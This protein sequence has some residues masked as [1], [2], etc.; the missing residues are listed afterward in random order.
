MPPSI[1]TKFLSKTEEK[2]DYFFT[3]EICQDKI[4]TAA[5]ELKQ[6][7]VNILGVGAADGGGSWE[8]TTIAVDKAL[9]LVEEKFPPG[10]KVNKVVLGLPTEYTQDGKI[11]ENK[12]VSIKEL[13]QKLSLVPLGF[14]EIPLAIVH[15]LQIQE[16]GPQTLILLRA[17]KELTVSLAR[18]GKITNNLTVA[19]TENI[20]SDL[21]RVI[22][23]FSD[24]EVL[25]SRI[26]IYDDGSNLE[27]TRQA[28]M[29]YPWLT[30]ASFLHF[31][32]IEIAPADLDIKAIAFA[33][34]GETTRVIEVPAT[35]FGFVKGE[36][37]LEQ[38]PAPPPKPAAPAPQIVLPKFALPRLRIPQFFLLGNLKTLLAQKFGLVFLLAA[39]ILILVGGGIA[40]AS[41]YLPRAQVALVLESQTLEQPLEVSL[42]SKIT[43]VDEANKE[44][45]G[46]TLEVEEKETKKATT[47]SKKTVGEP[48]RGELTIYNKTTNNKTFKKGTILLSSNNLKFSLDEEVTVASAS[49]SIDNLTF[50]KQNARLTAAN[51]GPEGNLGVGQEFHFDEFPTSSYTARNE[52]AFSGGISREISVVG[53]SDQEKLLATASTELT[54]QAKKDLNNKLGQGE[55]LIEKTL[56]GTITSKKFD[57]EVDEE[58]TELSLD[59][60][61]HFTISLFKEDDLL[62]LWEKNIVAAIPT[63][64]EFKRSETKIEITD[65][66]K[67][68]DGTW[69]L[70]ANCSTTLFPKIDT[71]DIQKNLAGKKLTE[72]DNYLRNLGNVAGYEIK[73]SQN[74]PWTKN[75]LPK[76]AANIL[77]ETRS[78]K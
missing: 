25:P 66:Q 21:E 57:K 20:A 56:S 31:P 40:A 42:N 34:A 72:V 43:V 70:K 4:K 6:G 13:L 47:T 74:L 53:R 41:W 19:R 48:A 54:E 50:G 36:D 67:K 75:M 23:S 45:P 46:L 49:E 12:L 59:L 26:L 28:L 9:S 58:A 29:N 71:L 3:L 52:V 65:L 61:M 7:E 11:E 38:E 14:V 27:T 73:F 35:D 62:N 33:G 2:S 51:I 55:K 24:I 63:G 44:I 30:K 37:V 5:C 64:F 60:A 68:K 16:G 77:I 18:V 76:I 69:V 22:T 10:V 32:K 15:L 39:L 1:L 8:E 17:G 78:R